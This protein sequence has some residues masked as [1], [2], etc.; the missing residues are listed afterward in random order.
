[1]ILPDEMRSDVRKTFIDRA[2]E[3]NIDISFAGSEDAFESAEFTK[4][5]KMR[6]TY[7]GISYE[8]VL[9]GKHQV[10]N[11]VTAI[12][13]C[14]KCGIDEESIRSGISLARWKCR[15]EILSTDPVTIIDGGHNPQ[16]AESLAETMNVMLA[17]SIKGKP[18][19]LLMGVMADKDVAGIL[20]AYKK[21]GINV[22]GAVTVTPEN[23]R[24]EPADVLA[25][26]INYVYNITDDLEVCPDAGEGAKRAYLKS[27][28]DGKV[29][30][31]TGSLYLTGQIRATLKGLIE[32]TT[33]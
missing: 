9:N 4:D 26:K 13:A 29:L 3:K 32:C 21:C 20:E 31:A 24:S 28:E 8:T 7:D 11:A 17:G 10:G 1:M 14:R 30:L 16:G 25:R 12:E 19:R 2:D 18:V 23:P 6:F 5:G 22:T 15:A 27:V 33:I